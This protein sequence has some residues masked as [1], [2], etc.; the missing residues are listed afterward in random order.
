MIVFVS[1]HVQIL[2]SCEMVPQVDVLTSD[3]CCCTLLTSFPCSF[4]SFRM[5]RPH[6]CLFNCIPILDPSSYKITC[7][8]LQSFWY[9]SSACPSWSL[10]PPLYVLCFIIYPMMRL[11][12]MCDAFPLFTSPSTAVFICSNDVLISE[13]LEDSYCCSSCSLVAVL[14]WEMVEKHLL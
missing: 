13:A 14:S 12:L 6:L 4:T 9:S 10:L 7:H 1:I 5:W 8:S 2:C 3:S 11:F